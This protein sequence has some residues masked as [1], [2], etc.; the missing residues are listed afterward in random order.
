MIAPPPDQAARDAIIAERE[1]NVVVIAGAGTGKTKTIIDRAVALLAPQAAAELPIDI[2][3]MALITFT[4]RA[5]G[6]L[7]FRIREHLLRELEESARTDA[8]RTDRLRSA[9]ANLDAAFIGTIHGFADRLLRLRPV[10]AQL[11]PAYTLVEDNAE[12]VRETFWR[13]RRAAEAGTLHAAL[14]AFGTTLPPALIDEAAGTLRA[15]VRAG[16]QME[17]AENAFGQLAS[18]EGT[19]ARMIDT[20]DV[21]VELPPI[22]DPELAAACG[23]VQRLRDMLATMRGDGLGHRRVRRIV[24]ALLHL[25]AAEEPA[26]AVRVVLEALRGRQLYKGRDFNDD[27]C[28]FSIYKAI[29]AERPIRDS[30]AEK[31][32]GPHRWLATR[33]VRLFPLVRAM[34]D[35]V[36]A[37]HEVVDYLDLL[38]NLR[39]LLRDNRAAR[40][41]YQSLFD[42]VF[43]DEFQDTDP[44]QCEIV[45]YLC[46]DTRHAAATTRWDSL[47]LAPGKLT[48]VGDPKQSIYRFR[49]AD[50]TMYGRAI[51]CLLAS[52]A[53]EQR[54]DTNFRS[55]PELIRFFN[56]Q[57]GKALGRSDGPAFDAQTGRANYE[58]LSPTATMPPGGIP[59]HILP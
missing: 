44:L 59:V 27:T 33:L 48:I 41:F 29:Y 28:G 30:L 26:E 8:T 58:D 12:L 54:L 22:P 42:H 7:R 1:R 18:L 17:R 32:R 21:D 51:E 45:F 25:H 39:N 20:R 6:E 40:Q 56:L 47:I 37:E 14:G 50:I 23:A 19:L 34:Y 5:A 52:G 43:V 3:R 13:L 57:L 2:R 10:E 49:R 55:R 24:G 15:A 4:R 31:L 38:I 46:E 35:R 11:S 53:L 9:L 36:K 16:L